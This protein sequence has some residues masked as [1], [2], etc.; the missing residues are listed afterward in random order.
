MVNHDSKSNI[1]IC[2]TSN[3]VWIHACNAYVGEFAGDG[4]VK[5]LCVGY[6]ASTAKIT[7]ATKGIDVII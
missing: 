1:F 3:N 6:S 5:A 2:N 4:S 7:D